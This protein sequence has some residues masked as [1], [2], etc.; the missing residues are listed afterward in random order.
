MARRF[1]PLAVF[2]I[3]VCRAQTTQGL[4]SGQVVD[5]EDGRPL[6]GAQVAYRNVAI[7]RSGVARTNAAGYYILPLLPP[8]QYRIRVTGDRY[9]AQ[10]LQELDLPVAAFLEINFRLRALGDVWEQGQY[11][12][13]FLPGTRSVL[14]FFGPDVDTT[15]SSSFEGNRGNR[16]GLESTVS[17][18][19]DPV[20]VR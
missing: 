16:G 10:E 6:A 1:L 7:N 9:Q 14:T 12:S 13:V 19:I 2:F 4:I 17:E 11:R 18:V 5:S 20:Q 3:T 15:K 8:G